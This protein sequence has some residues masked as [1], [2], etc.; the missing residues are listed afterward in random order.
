MKSKWIIVLLI[1]SLAVNM[2][3]VVTIGIQWSRHFTR[4]HPLHEEPPFSA[5]HREMLRRRLDLTDDQFRA[6][7]DVHDGFAD[8]MEAKHNVLREKRAALFELL[9]APDPDRERI[10][11]LLVEIS[12]HQADIERNV[13]DNLLELKDVLTPAQREKLLSLIDHKFQGFRKHFKHG[14]PAKRMPFRPE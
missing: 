12:V 7:Q 1:F 14:P 4:H 8:E 10:D 2:A 13:V 3:A 11:S 9:R 5:R 6:V